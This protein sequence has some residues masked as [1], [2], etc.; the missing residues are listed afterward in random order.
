VGKTNPIYTVDV[1]SSD[2]VTIELETL[3]KAEANSL[4]EALKQGLPIYLQLP[5]DVQL[6]SMYASVGDIKR[7]PA[8]RQNGKHQI[9]TIPLVEVDPPD[10]SITGSVRT[11]Q[12]LLD[13]CPTYEFVFDTYVDYQEVVVSDVSD[14]G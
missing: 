10:F 4:A 2:E 8:G 14:I 7:K 9:F 6:K 3:T 5:D 12:N 13:E 1:S 11:Y